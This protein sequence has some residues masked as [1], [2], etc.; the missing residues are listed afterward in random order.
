MKLA[1]ERCCESVSHPPLPVSYSVPDFSDHKIFEYFSIV[2]NQTV[3]LAFPQ[4]LVRLTSHQKECEH[5]PPS[6]SIYS[7]Y[8]IVN[9]SVI[10]FGGI[11]GSIQTTASTSVMCS[12]AEVFQGS[13][14]LSEHFMEQVSRE[15]LL[16]VSR[17]KFAHHTLK[18][19]SLS[20][21]NSK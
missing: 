11:T 12:M 13:E 16:N 2:A 1:D 15:M 8:C 18:S 14:R 6:N 3:I 21:H 4:S 10:N 20:I 5:T 19:S 9:S 17:T 7:C